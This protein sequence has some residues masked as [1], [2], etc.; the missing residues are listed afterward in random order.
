MVFFFFF[1]FSWSL[2]RCREGW[3]GRTGTDSL[4]DSLVIE[5]EEMASS[6]K[7]TDLG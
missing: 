1:F 6:L 2:Y 3:C 4:A 7:R 5:K